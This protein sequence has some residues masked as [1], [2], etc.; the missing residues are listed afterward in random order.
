MSACGEWMA[1]VVLLCAASVQ[2]AT[3]RGVVTGDVRHMPWRKGKDKLGWCAL[4]VVRDRVVDRTARTHAGSG[5]F[6]IPNLGEGAIVLRVSRPGFLSHTQVLTLDAAD[7]AP[8][9]VRLHRDPDYGLVVSPRT[10]TAVT[11]V[12]GES[13]AIECAAP[14][15]AGEWSAWLR[16]DCFSRALKVTGAQFKQE[17]VWHGTRDGWRITVP[18]PKDTP[19]DM[20]DLRVRYVDA[21]GRTHVST[22]AAAV[23]VLDAYPDDFLLMPYLDFHFNWLV[24]RPGAA[25]ETQQDYFRAASLIGPLW[26]SLG[27]DVG[28]EGDDHVA[29]F[30]YIVTRHC[31]VPVYL[32]FGNHDAAITDAG[33]EYYFGPRWQVRRVGPRI[34]IVLSHDLYQAG[35][36]MSDVQKAFVNA[37]L[38][39][40]HAEPDNRIIFLCGHYKPWR[41]GKP[42]PFFKLPFTKDQRTWFPGHSDGKVSVAFERLFMHALSVSSMHGWADLNYTGRVMRIEGWRRAMLLA[43]VALPSVTY[44]GPNN[45][46]AKRLSATVR[47]VGQPTWAPPKNL[48]TGGYFCDMPKTWAGLPAIRDARLRFMMRR[49]RYRCTGG[50]IVRSVDSDGGKTTVLYVRTDVTEPIK[51]VSVAPQ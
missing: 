7:P 42:A 26:V 30:H 23:Q 3:L 21:G 12:A 17:G 19:P 5:T 35:Y 1:A 45:G 13:F 49:G 47:R 9:H 4:R 15:G 28:F 32:A 46:T 48:Y 37:A 38:D 24:H 14:A 10:G 25:G 51:T 44:D 20:Y 27:D 36:R 50:R 29:M 31:R 18:V 8:I 22:Q 39:R 2:S 33:H 16:A 34:G 40:F 6:N 11:R 43:Q 41:P